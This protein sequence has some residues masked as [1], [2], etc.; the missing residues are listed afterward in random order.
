LYSKS[1]ISSVVWSQ[2]HTA[3]SQFPTEHRNRGSVQHVVV[4]Q[5]EIAGRATGGDAACRSG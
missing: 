2:P 1:T 5:L 4:G 3:L